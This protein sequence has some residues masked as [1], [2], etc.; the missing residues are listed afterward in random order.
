METVNFQCGHCSQVLAV[1]KD[2][3]GQQVR[4]PHCQQVV[5]APLPSPPAPPLP[6]PDTLDV[7]YHPPVEEYES[8][9][10]APTESEDLFGDHP[11]GRVEMPPEV[12]PPPPEPGAVLPPM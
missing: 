4:C 7:Q 6:F 2:H 11:S 10:S 5:V 3:L 9:F 1:S 12:P 8:I